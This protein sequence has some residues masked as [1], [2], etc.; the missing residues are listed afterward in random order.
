MGEGV[1]VN[2]SSYYSEKHDVVEVSQACHSSK[3]VP[4]Y[5]CFFCFV[6]GR[7][8]V[9]SILSLSMATISCTERTGQFREP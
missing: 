7:I 2:V 6:L 9:S 5:R 8:A 3:I 4:F 1:Y